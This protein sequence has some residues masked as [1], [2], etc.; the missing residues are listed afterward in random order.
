MSTTLEYQTYTYGSL[1]FEIPQTSREIIFNRGANIRS[2]EILFSIE[3]ENYSIKIAPFK[4]IGTAEDACKASFKTASPL[5]RDE[6]TPPTQVGMA[7]RCK[8][9]ILDGGQAP[10]IVDTAFVEDNGAII[11]FAVVCDHAKYAGVKS[12]FDHVVESIHSI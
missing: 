8:K 2:V 9:R 11:Q 6:D 3:A 1:Q 7:W 4:F 10:L 5:F 12:I